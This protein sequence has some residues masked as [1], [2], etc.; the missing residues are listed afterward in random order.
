[1]RQTGVECAQVAEMD[2]EKPHLVT[3]EE[4]LEWVVTF[5]VLSLGHPSCRSLVVNW[6]L[7]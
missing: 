2:G 4:Q 5:K 7:K 3:S 1:M 6:L